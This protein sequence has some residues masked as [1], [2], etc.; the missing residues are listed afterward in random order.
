M[1]D[2]GGVALQIVLEPRTEKRPQ[3]SLSVET[4]E[5]ERVEREVE[6]EIDRAIERLQSL[7]RRAT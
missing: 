5:L 2:Q 7:K 4:R 3:L 1:G 6:R